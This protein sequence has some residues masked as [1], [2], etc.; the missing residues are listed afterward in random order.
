MGQARVL[1]IPFEELEAAIIDEAQR[2]DDP[3]REIEMRL[4]GLAL[5]EATELLSRARAVQ[6]SGLQLRLADRLHSY[7]ATARDAAGGRSVVEVDARAMR[8]YLQKVLREDASEISRTLV[9]MERSGILETAQFRSRRGEGVACSSAVLVGTDLDWTA[10]G[11]QTPTRTRSLQV[12]RVL[13]WARLELLADLSRGRS[14]ADVGMARSR[15]RDLIGAGELQVA[16]NIGLELIRHFPKDPL[17]YYLAALAMARMGATTEALELLSTIPGTVLG[18]QV[19]ERDFTQFESNLTR[20][21]ALDDSGTRH[22]DWKH[23]QQPG[24][25]S[26][27]DLVRDIFALF[28]R[29]E[30]DTYVAV[31][32]RS[33]EA[34][35]AA[36]RSHNIYRALSDWL[37]DDYY[38]A[39]N[40]ATMALLAG[41]KDAARSYAERALRSAEAETSFWAIA[42]RLEAFAV[43]GHCDE[44]M[45]VAKTLIDPVKR[46][47]FQLGELASLRRQLDLLAL[48][49]PG[50][51]RILGTLP[52]TP[53]AVFTGH[54]MPLDMPAEVVRNH[55]ASLTTALA[56]AIGPEPVAH[57]FTGLA[58]GSDLLIVQAARKLNPSV[59]VHGVLAFEPDEFMRQSVSEDCFAG[60]G[61]DWVKDYS[62]ELGRL[63][64]LRVI[65]GG[66]MLRADTWS[67]LVVANWVMAGLGKLFTDRYAIRDCH[68]LAVTSGGEAEFAEGTVATVLDW[69]RNGIAA[70]LIDC[71]WRVPAPVSRLARK[72]LPWAIHAVV[73]DLSGDAGSDTFRE[74]RALSDSGCRLLPVAGGFHLEWAL[75]SDALDALAA[76]A[77]RTDLRCVADYLY[78]PNGA[79][80]H[81]DAVDIGEAHSIPGGRLLLSERL[82]AIVRFRFGLRYTLIPAGIRARNRKAKAL[83][84]AIA[85]SVIMYKM[86]R[87]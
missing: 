45:T 75:G 17:L 26:C 59:A 71:P 48:V 52:K 28:A 24:E 15:V 63:S 32:A 7:A 60:S 58:R 57:L 44:A 54:L 80:R 56:A 65:W 12:Y 33:L 14:M 11:T 4:I 79:I 77:T 41:Q 43:L 39:V 13:D 66:A 8:A 6:T 68:F 9:E 25:P 23:R 37:P 35:G 46:T 47:S 34:K 18:T 20:D 53:V 5:T 84:R 21:E 3:N 62:T 83:D 29:L 10:T 78:A 50:I 69:E 31:S 16:R 72:P 1:A 19:T 36:I 74:I 81:E 76:I 87:A 38:T 51:D 64:S 85:P 2:R 86:V 30:K 42:T 22:S 55:A 61:R 82:A 67:A 49:R 73:T 70:T 27:R 40:A